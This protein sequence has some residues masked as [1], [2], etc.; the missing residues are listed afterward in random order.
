MLLL[1]AIACSA[2]ATATPAPT[3]APLETAPLATMLE[4]TPAQIKAAKAGPTP[5]PTQAPTARPTPTQEIIVF[6]PY[7]PMNLLDYWWPP[8]DFYGQPVYGGTLRINYYDPLEHA[9][10]WSRFDGA[11]ARLRIPTGATLVMEDPYDAYAPVIPDLAEDWEIHEGQDGVTFYLRDDATWHNGEPFTCE[12]A[13]FSFE[14]MITGN[15][16]S[17]SHMQ[18]K[19]TNVLLDEMICFDNLTLEVKLG[20]PTAIPLHSFSNPLALVF[21][22]AWFEAGGEEAMFQ[23]ISMGIGPFKWM[24]GQRVGVDEQLFERNNDYFIPE[25]PYL[26]ELVIFGIIDPSARQAA[27]LTHQ[28]DWLWHLWLADDKWGQIRDYVDHDQIIIAFRASQ[29]N[30]RLWINARNTP[31]DNAKVR[32]AIVMGIDRNAAVQTLLDGYGAVGGFGYPPGNPWELPQEQRCTVPGWCVSQDMEDA[33]AEARAIL[34]AEGFDF[35]QSYLISVEANPWYTLH[36]RVLIEQLRLLGMRIDIDLINRVGYRNGNPP[37]EQGSWGDLLIHKD[38]VGFDE[39][40]LGP[41]VYLHC[42]SIH[43]YWIPGGPCD[44]GIQALLE[45]AWVENDPARRLALVHQ[46][47]LAAMRQYSSFPIYWELEVA[48]FWPDVRGYVHFPHQTGSFLK[49]MHMWIDPAHMNDT[50]YVG[51]VVGVP[52]GDW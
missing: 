8:T 12:D 42:E 36:A 47:E 49:F 44:E 29:G 38:T 20:D 41:V 48:A 21:N 43:N 46:T 28:T 32:Q 3:E 50:G 7:R 45:Q 51:Q 2:E 16:L 26:E 5:T 17:Q 30:F 40:Y 34:A 1:A 11:A 25:L 27:L 35:D 37:P 6:P 24:E 52:G 14:T 23:D 18:N 9:N 13:R 15:G 19:L 39:L 33:R 22:K 10:A 31:F 4:A